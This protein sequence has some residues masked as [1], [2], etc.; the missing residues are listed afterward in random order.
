MNVS[1]GRLGKMSQLV[2][3]SVIYSEVGL[4]IGVVSPILSRQI[5]SGMDHN[6]ARVHGRHAES[7]ELGF[8]HAAMACNSAQC[9]F[10]GMRQRGP[11]GR[12]SNFRC[13]N[14]SIILN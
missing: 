6:C 13:L 3:R 11:S 4:D 2:P 10:E 12:V 14:I 1:V 7:N 9:C 5:P 8:I